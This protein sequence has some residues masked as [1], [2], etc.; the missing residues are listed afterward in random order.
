MLFF[1]RFFSF[2]F[3]CLLVVAG[4]ITFTD[5]LGLTYVAENIAYIWQYGVEGSVT[6]LAG[7]V[8]FG[9][10]LVIILANLCI[11]APKAVK[12]PGTDKSNAVYVTLNTIENMARNA[13]LAVPGVVSVN[14]K[15]K[16]KA[17]GL[18]LRVKISVSFEDKINYVTERLQRD[19]HDLIEGS[20]S[21]PVS[22]VEVLVVKASGEKDAAGYRS[23]AGA[24]TDSQ[25]EDKAN[26]REAIVT[27]DK[28]EIEE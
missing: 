27:L 1:N 24:D 26:T 2:V 5:G 19:I 13:A 28:G 16:S 18:C 22:S 17:K 14:T 25:P 21:L 20:T 7:A 11:K 10:G 23:K 15:I 12:V 8:V 3:G 6:L 4:V 9:L